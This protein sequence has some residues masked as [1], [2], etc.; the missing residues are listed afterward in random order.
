[1][2]Q[3]VV[4]LHA[5]EVALPAL[6]YP[7]KDL[8]VLRALEYDKLRFGLGLE[9]MAVPD[10][11][12]DVVTLATQAVIGLMTKQ[13]L[14]PQAI[15]RLYLGT[16][17][18]VDG[19]KPTATYILSLLE[20]YFAPQYG[21]HCFEHCDVVDLTF[22]CIGAVDA[23]QNCNDWV[24]NDPAR[25]AIVVASDTARYRLNSTGEY[26]QGAGAVALL[27]RH[28][29]ALLSFGKYWGVSTAGVHDFYK[30]IRSQRKSELVQDI[31]SAA[32]ST[33]DP[34]AV[35]AALTKQEQPLLGNADADLQVHDDTPVFDG[36][37]S[38][39]CYLDRVQGALA[40]F[41]AL[42]GAQNLLSERWHG[43]LFHL[44]YAFQ[45][46]R[47]ASSALMRELIALDQ[48]SSLFPDIPV[49]EADEKAFAKS[50]YY[51]DFVAHKLAPAHLASMQVGNLYT[52]SIFLALASW[53]EAQ[54]DQPITGKLGFIA[55]GSG[56]KSKVF[57]GELQPHW[58]AAAA[59][60]QLHAKLANREVIDSNTYEKLHKGEG[61][62]MAK[63][64]KLVQKTGYRTDGPTPWLLTYQLNSTIN[65]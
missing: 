59:H 9:H 19:A 42:S 54:K 38:N 5:L 10:A 17:S 6:S 65:V 1:M 57:E 51:K 43:L 3:T 50:D 29:P 25:Q 31:L 41:S 39:Q 8:A 13:Q 56:S 47:M 28:D 7:I 52:G 26:T 33:A 23:L 48:W 16:E 63:K 40:Q 15:G 12:E 4:G 18:A 22:A 61:E 49:A 21:P 60:I 11:D 14:A 2:N 46:K 24:A 20:S 34:A 44:P 58:Q 53:L 37:Y 64:A 45:G 27:L 55:Y 62:V 32:Q 35:L 30:P 36:Q